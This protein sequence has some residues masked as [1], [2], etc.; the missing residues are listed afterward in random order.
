MHGEDDGLVPFRVVDW[1]RPL[2]GVDV[3]PY[4]GLRHELHNEPEGETVVADVAAW[5][6]DRVNDRTEEGR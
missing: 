3:R 4:A 6:R 2:K 5:L 1:F